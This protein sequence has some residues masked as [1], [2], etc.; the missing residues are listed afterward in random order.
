[1]KKKDTIKFLNTFKN[2]ILI[3]KEPFAIKVS[4]QAISIVK[5]FYLNRLIQSFYISKNAS[6]LRVFLQHTV[7]EIYFQIRKFFLQQL[8]N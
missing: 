5:A 7:L 2:I 8:K 4:V 6:I 3:K 1:M